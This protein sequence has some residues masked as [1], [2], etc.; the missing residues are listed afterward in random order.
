MTFTKTEQKQITGGALAHNLKDSGRTGKDLDT[1]LEE[2]A[3]Q[4]MDEN[5]GK[6]ER[7]KTIAATV[8]ED[9]WE[10]DLTGRRWADV[11][12]AA[13]QRLVGMGRAV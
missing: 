10:N 12:R 8:L 1:A 11:R 4:I 9:I 6:D 2:A 7:V 3:Q 13:K 5:R